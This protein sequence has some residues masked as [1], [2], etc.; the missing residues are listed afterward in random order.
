MKF[1]L[2]QKLLLGFGG[3]LIIV[4]V[5]GA[6]SIRK[7]SELGQSIDVI[8]RENYRSVIA[9]QQMK[10]LLERIDSGVLFELLGY[11]KEGGQLIQDNI[12]TFESALKVESNN[13]TMPGE[14]EACK[15]LKHY[16]SDYKAALDKVRDQQQ[17]HDQRNSAYFNTLLPLFYHVKDTANSIL[18]MNQQNMSDANDRARRKA[19]QTRQQMYLL[20]LSGSALAVVFTI[21]MGRWI[22]NPLRQLTK[23]A[24][25]I[26]QGNLDLI[27]RSDSTDEIGQLSNAFDA[28]AASLREFRRS[29]HSRMQ[30]IQHATQQTFNSLPDAIAIVDA[31]GMIEVA[32]ALAGEAFALKPGKTL[33]EASQPWMMS[34]FEETLRTNHPTVGKDDVAIL[35]CF[36]RGEEHF[37]RPQA[38]PILD[39]K[40]QSTGVTLL[41]Q[42]VTQLQQ[43]DEL[44]RDL[45]S[46]VSHQLKTPLTSLRMALYLLLG[47]KIGPLLPKQEELLLAARE[48]SERLYGIIEDLLDIGRMQSGRVQMDLKGCDPNQLAHVVIS[49]FVTA[50]Q[51]KGVFLEERL[52]SGLPPVWA[53]ATRISHVFANLLSNALRYTP[54]AGRITVSARAEEYWVWFTVSDTGTGIPKEYQ[55]Q[56]FEPFFRVP[57]QSGVT[58]AGL[59]LTIAKE[60]VEAHGGSIHVQS[61]E[62]AGCTFTFSLPRTDRTP[63]TTRKDVTP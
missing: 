5:I 53:D 61:E 10:E 62:G 21:F 7:T 36:V 2:R 51:D 20:L 28:M 30:R 55:S 13:I 29:D 44:K 24:N 37:F 63:N 6:Q 27:V 16:Y 57:G 3:L 12:K 4:I 19:A 41:F 47:E 43:Q 48:D 23:S 50:A 40:G 33:K 11:E 26:R 49:Q 15:K 14:G 8:L 56:I 60:I 39:S 52:P 18:Q 58:G 32:T 45:L 25:D 35:Q 59:G 1:G 34:M 54:P 17:P 46:T 31:E 22:L 38:I 9:C 42:D